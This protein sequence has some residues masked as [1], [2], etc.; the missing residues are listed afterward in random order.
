MTAAPEASIVVPSYRG[1][2][3][4]P[5][6]FDALAAQHEGSP[7][8]EV[9]IVIDGSDD[10][11]AELVS[12]ERRIA[13][14]CLQFP[15]NRGRVEALN[16]GFDIARGAVLIRCDDDLL[17][18]PDYVE[19]HVAAHAG[20][21]RGAVG[22][23]LNVFEPTPYST[24]YGKDADQRFREEAYAT[25][26]ATSWRYW[27]GNCSVPRKLWQEI[28]SYDPEY[29][30]YGWEDVDYGFR[31]AM[32]GYAVDLLPELETVHRA[33]AVTTEIR[34]RRAGQ[35]AAARRIF[36]RKHGDCQLPTAVP[37][38]SLWNLAVRL[39]AHVVIVVGSRR[40]G[41]AVDRLLPV[42][43]PAL[44]RKLVAVVV[45]GAALAGYRRPSR[46]KDVF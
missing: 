36:E 45:E 24:A 13:V 14:Q 2:S 43:P 18:G 33:A 22:L 29:R 17:P 28:G 1:A 12:T 19:H 34:A 39:T 15:E 16:A 8:F 26:A 31:I 7:S 5:E 41:S 37:G 20:A 46:A 44:G 35:A 25:T 23:Y 4:L 3:R 11:S 10:G 32:A 6:L 9:I 38:L 30:L 21:P 27:A 40:C 42:L